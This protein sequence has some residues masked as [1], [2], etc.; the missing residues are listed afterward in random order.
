MLMIVVVLGRLITLTSMAM[1]ERMLLPMLHI[2]LM[3]ARIRSLSL[4]AHRSCV[5]APILMCMFYAA[6][7]ACAFAPVRTVTFAAVFQVA[8]AVSVFIVISLWHSHHLRHQHARGTASRLTPSCAVRRVGVGD[9]C[10]N[11]W[12]YDYAC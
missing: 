12:P 5:C 9:G 7:C 10:V 11:R 6:P 8:F 1:L 2:M 4:V 3:F